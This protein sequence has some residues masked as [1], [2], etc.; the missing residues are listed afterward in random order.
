MPI[1]P[2]LEEPGFGMRGKMKKKTKL[3]L[4]A[5]GS[6][7]V[8]VIVAFFASTRFSKATFSIKPKSLPLSINGTYVAQGAAGKGALAYELVTIRGAASTTV[9]ATDGPKISTKAHGTVR[10]YNSYS[11]QPVKLIAGT[12][13]ANDTGLVYRLSSSIVIP[14]YTKNQGTIMPGSIAAN[15]VADQA[16]DA[17]NIGKSDGLSD[18][19]FLGYKGTPKYESVFARIASDIVGGYVGTKKNL[20]PAVLAST[21]AGLKTSLSNTLVAKLKNSIPPE[22]I[23]FDNGFAVKYSLP[24]TDGNLKNVAVV[25]E[26]GTIYG[27]IIKKKDLISKISGGQSDTAFSKYGYET[28][29]F[30]NLA[31]SFTNMKDFI[32][33]KKTS[34]VFKA[35]GDMKLVSNVP[36]DEIRQKLEGISLSGTQDVFRTYNSVIETGTG[37]LVPPW[38]KIPT[39][40][41]RITIQVKAD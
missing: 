10:V 24:Q 11:A 25:S 30:D 4:I 41:A 5:L 23:M 37:E 15:I 31:F 3:A 39:D 7:V 27:V 36:V 18:F 8:I 1:T 6:I 19:K 26:Q 28:S 20:A 16:G 14:G 2:P 12:R 40:P 21:T 34:L 29:G 17:Y 9:P 22:Y 33:E 38:A 32:P 13:M 35:K